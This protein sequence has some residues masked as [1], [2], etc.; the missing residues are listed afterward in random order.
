MPGA[1][2][3]ITKARE[4]PRAS[5]LLSATTAN[6]AACPA[7]RAGISSRDFEG[8]ESRARAVA[9]R[10]CFRAQKPLVRSL[11][12]PLLERSMQTSTERVQLL[13]VG[14]GPVG[15][16]A[17]LTAARAGLEVAVVDQSFRSLSRGYA[18]L[19]HGRTFEL[20]TELGLGERLR[21]AGRTISRL[22]LRVD[23]EEPLLLEL[24][25]PVLAVAQGRLEEALLQAL[26]EREVD[27]RTPHQA[28]VIQQD[29]AGARVR[30][31][32]R[33][34]TTEG[35]PEQEPAWEAVSS[36]T[37]DANFVVGADG[38]DSRVRAA[39]GIEAVKVGELETFAMFEV[40]NEPGA[41]LQ[42]TFQNGLAS[43][44]VPLAGGR[45]R[46][47]FQID[48]ELD[49]APDSGRLRKLTGERTRWLPT[50]ERVEWSTVIHF[51]RRLCRRFGSGRVWLAGDAAHVTSPLGAQSMN[52]GIYEAFDLARRVANCERG[53]SQLDALEQYGAE[54]Q[55]EW[56]KLL[57]FHVKYELLPRAPAWLTSYARKL[58]PV[59]PASGGELRVLL[60]RLGLRIC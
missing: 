23:E 41:E 9:G 19:L 27:I 32:Q 17:G 22:V 26:R 45:A 2:R 50:S 37:I 5:P 55:R 12:R 52:L 10:A 60:E 18:T 14:G 36:S 8:D 33:E 51:E 46:L 29:A 6:F 11:L 54:R 24:P 30:L 38:Y 53:H 40:A 7:P 16:V 31:V 34:L 15:L 39:M 57:G 21:E 43:S 44:V 4:P 49:E 56:H 3:S 48:R 58:A 28:T 59:L 13:V 47:G 35:R 25:T 42:L 20:L 1:L